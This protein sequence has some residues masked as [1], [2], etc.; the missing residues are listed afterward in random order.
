MRKL[1]LAIGVSSIAFGALALDDVRMGS[2]SVI[3]SAVYYSLPNHSK[4]DLNSLATILYQP[5]D[6]QDAFEKG[7]L[8]VV[9]RSSRQFFYAKNLYEGE[10]NGEASC[11]QFEIFSFNEFKKIYRENISVSSKGYGSPFNWYHRV[12]ISYNLKRGFLGNLLQKD[13]KIGSKF[14]VAVAGNTMDFSLMIDPKTRTINGDLRE[15]LK[16]KKRTCWSF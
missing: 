5:Y 10:N 13:I 7:T 16:S 14:F 4:P 2:V 3:K 12:A 1:L 6:K 8:D 15:F 11:K 9:D